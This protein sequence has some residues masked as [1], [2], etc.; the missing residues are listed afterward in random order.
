MLNLSFL[1]L[2][3]LCH[4]DPRVTMRM[5]R[6]IARVTTECA[7]PESFVRGVQLLRFFFQL[8]REE[9]IETPLQRGHH[10]SANETPFKW[11]SAGVPILAKRGCC[12]G[13]FF[14]IFSG[15]PDQYY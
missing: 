9:R 5:R 8:M 4:S 3:T 6:F 2:Y 13:S 10:R 11:R 12:L 14:I 1:Y 7:D 15:D